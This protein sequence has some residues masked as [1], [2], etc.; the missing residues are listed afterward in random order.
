MYDLLLS[1][2][3]MV[4]DPD[5]MADLLSEKLGIYQHKNWRQAFDNHPYIAHFL[6]VHKSLAMSPTRVEPQWHLDKPNPGDPFFHDHLESLMDFQGRHRPMIT[7]AVVLTM[8]NENLGRLIDRL[9]R[10]K[11]PFRLAQRTKEM[12]FDRL[13]V[14]MTPEEIDYQPRVDGGLCIEIIPTEAPHFP[15][16]IF[17]NPPQPTDFKDGEMVRVTRRGF[18]V[19]NLDYTLKCCAENMDLKTA[20]PVRTFKDEGYKLGRFEFRAKT[21]ATLDVLEPTQWDSHAGLYLNNWGPGLYYIRISVVNLEAKAEMLREKGVNF[22]WIESSEAVDGR[23]LIRVDP[24]ELKGQLFE[25]EEHV[26]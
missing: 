11:M 16:E 1:A 5:G 2:D 21:S 4:P 10:N 6:R 14:G 12:P 22:E 7:H 8:T 15:P 26:L 23:P 9:H 17:T 25:F 13:W 20:G 3:M 18:L 24:A 19:R